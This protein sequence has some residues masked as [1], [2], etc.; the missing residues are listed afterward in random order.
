MANTI[1]E[2]L[3]N[4]R[5]VVI[6]IMGLLVV[7]GLAVIWW[8]RLSTHVKTDDSTVAGHV[9]PVSP[10][11]PGTVTGV[12]FDDNQI[13][14]AGQVLVQL[15]PRDYQAEV[16]KAK[17]ALENAKAQVNVAT[18][19]VP[20]T[21]EQYAAQVTQAQGT[22]SASGAVVG[23][24]QNALKEA[25]AAVQTARENLAQT[26]ATLS[27]AQEDL[28]R[29]T[30][31]DPR[32]VSAQQRN[33]IR[34]AYNTAL[35]SRNA[36]QANVQ[37][38]IAR[39]QQ[40]QK[41]IIANRARVQ[42]SQGVLAQAQSQSNQVKIQKGQVVSSK[43]N[44]AQAEA[45]LKQAQLNLSYT[46][47]MAPIN[48]KA[49][50]KSVEVGQRVQPGQ[51][52]L[53]LVERDIWVV[54]NLKETQMNKVRP[55]QMVDIR[56]DAFPKHEFEGVVDSIAPASGAQFALLPPDNAT[57]NFTKIVQRIPVKILFTEKSIR[58]YESL[59]VP[60]MSTVITI[61]IKE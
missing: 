3:K 46:R 4:T 21:Q 1:S 44:V 2:K 54:A 17:A 23:Q 11:V 42:Q 61:H 45:A 48:G 56:V 47:I 7:I 49:G 59:L 52:L 28:Q 33:A 40:V 13:V 26:E 8:L 10:R 18:A 32:A 55:G 39:V 22:L 16:L 5:L 35:A 53:S 20:L 31:V 58:G 14:K 24:S 29:Y 60:G 19:G 34:T 37:Q 27:K 12:Y 25:Q 15:D 38:A 41:E 43:A 51:P 50:R 9:H 36:A 30:A 6:L 57:G